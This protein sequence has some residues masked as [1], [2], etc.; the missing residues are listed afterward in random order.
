MT[1][2]V[3]WFLPTQGDSRD[4]V[5]TGESAAPG[6][7]WRAPTL[8]YLDVVARTAE[9]GGF[10]SL[11]TPT[12]SWCDDAWVV[13]SF[14]AARTRRIRF[15]VA[16]RPGL[17]SP[18]AAAVQAA[19]FQR[20]SGGRL[21]VNIVTGGDAA[22]QR[23]YGDH[24]SAGER[25]G[26][27]AEFLTAYRA[28]L[29][30]LDGGP[31]VVL[32]GRHVH[33]EGA[34]L[35][36]PTVPRPPVFVGGASDRAKQVAAEHADVHL[37]W[38]EPPAAVAEHVARLTELADRAGRTVASGIRLH[39]ITRETASEAWTVAEHL[40]SRIPSRRIEET[41]R[42]LRLVES[43]GQR[44]MVA[45]HDSGRIRELEVSPNLWTGFGLVRG[46]VGTALVGSHEQVA[47]R[48]REYR[49]HGITHFV[50]SGQP[51]VEEALQFA[52]GVLP[53]LQ[54]TCPA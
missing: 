9:V 23:A 27:T 25:Y 30:T 53:R 49:G 17:V 44:R 16:F 18:T 45:L 28:A 10:E 22:E 51:H 29:D 50:L 42:A 3:H 32:R 35:Q 8:D 47:D 2:R 48:I 13:S 19:T 5:S 36:L 4:I 26:R 43:E 37:T 46:G 52:E 6:D 21:S 33:V 7:G 38:G 11:L 41:Q 24:L 54:H 20:H 15:L 34:R 31:P 40:R 12:G 1:I 39:V 14:L